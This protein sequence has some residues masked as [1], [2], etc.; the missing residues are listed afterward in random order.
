MVKKKLDTPHFLRVM[1][2]LHPHNPTEHLRQ[3]E[4]TESTV[5]SVV[6][7]ASFPAQLDIRPTFPPHPT[8]VIP[9]TAYNRNKKHS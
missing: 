3:V 7:P 2:I 6:V 5:V 9:N 8:T 1:D 4:Y